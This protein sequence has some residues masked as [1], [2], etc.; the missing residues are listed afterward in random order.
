MGIVEEIS[1]AIVE[2]IKQGKY[3]P[4]DPLRVDRLKKQYETSGTTVREA[5]SRLIEG[6]IVQFEANR[7]FS[8][9]KPTKEQIL[10]LF[11]AVAL[12][13]AM[14]LG[15]SIEHGD[16]VWESRIVAAQYQ[17][18]KLD[19]PTFEQFQEKNDE[20]HVA[21]VSGCGSTNLLK[22]REKLQQKFAWIMRVAY[23][24]FPGK[25]TDIDKE[26]SAIAQAALDRNKSVAV[27]L[28]K[29][30]ILGGVENVLNALFLEKKR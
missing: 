5:L 16:D 22:M 25:L 3:L 11:Q 30:H 23:H 20:F 24:S 10:D 4:G 17:L 29:K 28:I 27:N 1:S 19:D 2:E 8:L 18:S 26:H 7:G 21:L 15:E 14:L 9:V 13:D 6:G 12:M